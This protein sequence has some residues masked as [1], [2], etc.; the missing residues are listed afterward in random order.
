MRRRSASALRLNTLSFN[1]SSQVME[2]LFQNAGQNFVSHLIKHLPV[3]TQLGILYGAKTASLCP[4]SLEFT[5][6]APCST[7]VNT[8]KLELP[9]L[10]S[11]ALGALAY[12]QKF[13]TF[14]SALHPIQNAGSTAQVALCVG[15]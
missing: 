5:P 1:G 4:S 2:N 6:S 15:E 12:L 13:R 3:T 9:A 14:A 11:R 7:K 8:L 10:T